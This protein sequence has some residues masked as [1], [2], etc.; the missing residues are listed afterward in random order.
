M[1]PNLIHLDWERTFEALLIVIVLASI[2]ERALAVLFETELFIRHL[3]R[4]GLKALIAVVVSIVVCFV[5]QFDAL[6]MIVL[7]P[8][9]TKAG[10][11]IT[12]FLI[13]G[14]SKASIKLFHDVMNI[15]SSAYEYRDE[16]QAD[17]AATDAEKQSKKAAASGSLKASLSAADR[18]DKSALVAR[19][20]ADRS[21]SSVA[22]AAADTAKAAATAARNAASKLRAP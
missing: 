9:T 17:K 5:W 20:I 11:V 10:Y 7:T 14:G 12:G 21:G 22:A 4:P 16:I 19:R 3:D 2:I 13:A 8:E 6:S 18:A 1:D 15:K